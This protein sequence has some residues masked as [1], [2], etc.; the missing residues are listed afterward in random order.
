ME[1]ED[2]CG[3]QLEFGDENGEI[4]SGCKLGEKLTCPR[5]HAVGTL[6]FGDGTGESPAKFCLNCSCVLEETTIRIEP[7]MEKPT[8]EA[9]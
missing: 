1:D 2:C 8:G 9:C 7:E 6:V 5:C 4:G 3:Q